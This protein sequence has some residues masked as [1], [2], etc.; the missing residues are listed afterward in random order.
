MQ[1]T[2]YNH[3]PKGHKLYQL[4]QPQSQ[5]LIDFD[6]V[7]LTHLWQ[8]ISPPTP[9][10]G[11]MP[12]LRLLDRFAQD[13]TFFDDDPL[14]ELRRRGLDV[15]DF[16]VVTEWDAYPVVGYLLDMWDITGDYVTAVVND[17]YTRDEDVANDEHLQA[18]MTAAGQRDH[19]NVRGCP[20]STPAQSSRRCSRA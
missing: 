18:W 9:V 6:F 1:M 8:Q 5:S 15:D 12:L 19:G 3:L 14:S 16:T 17:L 11:Y 7:L 10:S 2:M 4:L 13:R 20:R